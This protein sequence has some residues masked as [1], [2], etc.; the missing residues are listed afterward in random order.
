MWRAA[1]LEAQLY[2][3]VEADRRALGQAGAVVGMACGSGALGAWLAGAGIERIAIDLLEPLVLW[4]GSS[5]F[6][7]MVGAT[8]LRGPETRTDF[9][10]VLR[11]TGFAFAPGLL[12]ALAFLPPQ[13]R[14][15]F[16]AT[17]L[18]DLWILAG[19]VVAVRQ[20]LDFSTLRALGTFGIAYALLW[21]VLW[22]FLT[23]PL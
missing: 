4:L 13:E 17:V 22:A 21:L 23:L 2:E 8:F 10:E 20:A 15:G 6:A 9:A 12:R 18:A 11:T 16:G 1:R 7:Y 3:E 14:L 19:A 5:T